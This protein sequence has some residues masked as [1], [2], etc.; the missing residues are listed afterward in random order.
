[1]E[2]IGLDQ[3]DI[4]KIKKIFAKYP[5]IEKVLLYGSR[6]KGKFKPFSDIDLT[7][8]GNTIDTT[9]LQTIELELDDLLLPNKFDISIFNKIANEQLVK[10]INS[11]GREFV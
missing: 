6:A 1:M 9:L 8:V 11:I 5:Q 7:L 10:E 4:E 3:S 2:N